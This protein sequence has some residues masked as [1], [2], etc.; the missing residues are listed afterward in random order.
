LEDIV[1][2][3]EAWLQ[4]RNM[5]TK[6]IQQQ[7][8]RAQQRIKAQA[9]TNK[10]E[11]TFAVGDKVYLKLQPHIQ[12]FVASRSNQK[13]SFKYMVLMRSYKELAQWITN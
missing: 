12:T 10:S 13:L 3:L 7:L 8:S 4:D 1:P 2:D 9:G 6:L 5:L 11:R